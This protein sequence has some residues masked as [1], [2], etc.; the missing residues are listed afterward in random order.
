MLFR[1]LTEKKILG[2]KIPFTPGVIPRRRGKLAESIGDTVGRQLLTEDAFQRMLQGEEMQKKVR[3]FIR[4]I[5]NSLEEEERSLEEILA[6]IIP[7]SE[8]RSNIE[9]EFKKL[10]SRGIQSL[11]SKE[12]IG[13]LIINELEDIETEKISNYFNTDEYKELR[14]KL[15]DFL[16]NNLHQE[17]TKERLT[18]FIEEKL[19]HIKEGGQTVDGILPEGINQGL[20]EWLSEQGPEIVEGLVDFLNSESTKSKINHKIEE[21]LNNNPLMQMVGGFIDEDKI[22]DQFLDHI[23]NFLREED[24][25]EELISQI[26]QL[27][28]SILETELRTLINKLDDDNLEE[29]SEF[30]LTRLA[31]KDMLDTLFDGLEKTFSQGLEKAQDLEGK[32]NINIMIEEVIDNLMGSQFL[33]EFLE[34]WIYDQVDDLSNRP[35]KSYFENVQTETVHK[36]ESG[37]LACL[38]YVTENHLGR[39]FANLDF[40]EMVIKQ[41]NTFDVLEV[42]ALI[43]NVIETELKAITW[44]GAV[45]GLVLGLITPAISVF[46][47]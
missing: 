26:D 7:D 28:D 45:L 31:S 30:L 14:I 18:I 3:S 2:M 47:G 9:N 22:I 20:K 4:E 32:V 1:P 40:E 35:L 6:D 36:L 29:I 23:I 24:N 38:E 34:S 44:F 43:L 42:E 41:V 27:L 15:R 5:M 11:L 25:Q 33:F 39:V 12:K 8:K 46:M 17:S 21:F 16:L 19:D 10:T 13:E 37:L